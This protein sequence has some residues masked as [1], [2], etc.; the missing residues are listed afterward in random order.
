MSFSCC[1]DLVWEKKKKKKP[2]TLEMQEESR[3]K[4]IPRQFYYALMTNSHLLE[5][6]LEGKYTH[7]YMPLLICSLYIF[8][9]YYWNFYFTYFFA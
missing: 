1:P 5:A 4:E 6:S 3:G 8:Y 7:G 2:E 9:L